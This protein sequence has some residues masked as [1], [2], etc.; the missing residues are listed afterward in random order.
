MW[1]N[2]KWSTVDKLNRLE[3]LVLIHSIIYYEFDEN[4]IT[5]EQY[6]KLSRLTAKKVAQYKDTKLKKTMYGYAFK[7][8]DGSTGFDLLFKLKEEDKL[9]LMELSRMVLG[10][11]QYNNGGLKN[12]RKG[13][14]TNRNSK[15]SNKR[16]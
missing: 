13:K 8:F 2:S 11:Y 16:K 6:N 14:K 4:V 3:R 15:T 9:Y 12:G 10:H 1:V 5:D 7:D